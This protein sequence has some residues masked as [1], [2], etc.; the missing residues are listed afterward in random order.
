[1]GPELELADEFWLVAHD[2]VG[3]KPQ[4]PP[5]TLGIGVA[6]ALVAELMIRR[7]VVLSQGRLRLLTA[8]L[9]DDPALAPL[10]SQ[11]LAEDKQLRSTGVA[12]DPGSQSLRDWIAFLAAESRAADLVAARLARAGVVER[13]ERR[14]LTGRRSVTYVPK[15]SSTAGW[16]AS[17]I[18]TAIRG[19]R[20]VDDLDLVLAG[21]MLATGLHQRALGQLEPHELRQLGQQMKTRMHDM[22]RELIHHAEV[23]VG[24]I[25][26]I[27]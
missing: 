16:P 9:P 22:L 13:Q 4:L 24:E 5:P 3:G 1:M 14:K 21:L 7:C 18:S 8:T 25:V 26:M 2:T 6:A 10:M 27:R 19:G 20:Y 12:H 15:D 23:A 11:M 17:R